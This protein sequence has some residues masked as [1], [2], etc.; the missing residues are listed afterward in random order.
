M[1]VRSQLSGVC[2][3]FCGSGLVRRISNDVR[4]EEN[5]R[6][7]GDRHEARQRELLFDRA[8]CEL[9]VEWLV[10]MMEAADVRPL[11]PWAIRYAMNVG[12]GAP[13]L[14]AQSRFARPPK[15]VR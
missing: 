1:L 3:P 10:R 13:H 11:L 4:E 9:G 15:R 5:G 6:A 12:R 14:W 8:S 2:D 7:N